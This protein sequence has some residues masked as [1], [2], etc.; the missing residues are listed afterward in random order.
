MSLRLGSSP[1]RVAIRIFSRRERSGR[2]FLPIMA[3]TLIT[4][5]GVNGCDEV[6]PAERMERA[7]AFLDKG[8]AT[9]AVIELKKILQKQP[10]DTAA[11]HL[12]ARVY[13]RL[14]DFYSAEKELLYV[15]RLAGAGEEIE[16]QLAGLWS[17]WN[18]HATLLRDLRIN[19]AWSARARAEAFVLRGDAHA[20]LGDR[21]DAVS[22]YRRALELQPDNVEAIVGLTRDAKR[23]NEAVAF[24]KYLEKGLHTAPD[25]PYFKILQSG[26]AFDAGAYTE[27]VAGYQSQLRKNPQSTA[28]RL[29][30]AQSLMALG[31]RDDARSEVELVLAAAPR[32]PS[33]HYLMAILETQAG[34]YGAAR[35]H[36][37][38]A[39]ATRP[40]H[41]P[42]MLLAGLANF[43]L[44]SNEFSVHIVDK[45]V[46][47]IIIPEASY[48]PSGSRMRS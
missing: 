44:E 3:L 26:R 5:M 20:A 18:R 10:S 35:S 17:R 42:S 11:R 41:E 36:S 12:L 38:R 48:D 14:G 2:K 32:H 4:L 8:R 23:H 25:N 15:R 34:L 13:F 40:D 1:L 19:P 21:S 47:A 33:A 28:L 43:A 22:A 6:E 27:A 39:L 46:P 7:R 37:I 9:G 30:L 24:Q 16:L 29:G 45:R 31:R